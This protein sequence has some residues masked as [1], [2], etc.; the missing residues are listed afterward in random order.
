MYLTSYEIV[1]GF[2]RQ[3]RYIKLFFIIFYFVGIIGIQSQYSRQLFIGLIPFVLLMSF[4]V[5]LLF[6]ETSIDKKSVIC[7]LTICLLSYLIEV[8]GVKTQSIFG[9]YNYGSGLGFKISD[10]PLMIGIN[11][12]MLVYC[13]ASITDKLSIHPILKI[14][15]ASFLMLI[16]DVI[17]EHIAP[18]LD[19]WYWKD[20]NVPLQN[21][22][23]WFFLA[24]LFQSLL[25][26]TRFQIRNQISATIFT[27]Q[28][29][30]FLSLII[31]FNL[32]K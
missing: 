27:C 7:L 21:Y 22:I 23:A 15:I 8:I 19:M 28:A 4:I 29:L 5:I 6:H 24:V 11:W 32:T 14:S 26:M 10:T 20:N 17:I 1:N 31:L 13:S 16:Y 2:I 9:A 30:F 25:R 12:V 3:K 18:F